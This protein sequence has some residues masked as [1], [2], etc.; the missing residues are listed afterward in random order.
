MRIPIDWTEAIDFQRILGVDCELD[1]A[2]REGWTWRWESDHYVI[3]GPDDRHWKPRVKGI[4]SFVS[5]LSGSLV[6]TLDDGSIE[7]ITW[8]EKDHV[9]FRVHFVRAPQPTDTSA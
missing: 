4:I 7:L 8:R 2:V 5:Y 3:E 6:R 9:G 1:H